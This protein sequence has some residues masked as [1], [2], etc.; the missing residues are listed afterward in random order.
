MNSINPNTID[1][2]EVLKDENAT[3][4]YGDKG[5]NGVVV[6]TTKN[7]NESKYTVKLSGEALYLINGKEVKKDTADKLNPDNITSVNVLKGNVA[8]K[9]YGEKA[10]YGVVEIITEK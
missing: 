7:E 2:V 9:K 5:K 4:K 3:I 1:K 10:K 8:I 6:I